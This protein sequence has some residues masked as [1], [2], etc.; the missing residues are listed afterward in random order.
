M[1]AGTKLGKVF[2]ELRKAGYVVRA[3]FKCCGSC[4][5]S[6]IANEIS[7]KIDKAKA[8]GKEPTLPKGSI[9]YHQQ[10][11]EGIRAAYGR[12]G[13]DPKA[14]LYLKFGPVHT[15]HGEIGKPSVQAGQDLFYALQAAG[16]EVEWD[17]NENQ[18]VAVKIASAFSDVATKAA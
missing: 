3:N 7:E 4:A 16:I 6:A 1:I 14:K 9:F 12:N 2:K 8:A 15:K 17:G 5:G 11:A 10:D 18:C 13:Y